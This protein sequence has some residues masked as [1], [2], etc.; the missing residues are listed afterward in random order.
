MHCP[1]TGTTSPAV[2]SCCR[3]IVEE[4]LPLYTCTDSYTGASSSGN[5]TRSY[6]ELATL[7]YVTGVKHLLIEADAVKSRM[8]MH[9][10][11]WPARRL[12]ACTA[13]HVFVESCRAAQCR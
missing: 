13:Q 6:N 12:G 8:K 2:N 10:S 9:L 1:F 11:P 3:R 4:S 7:M 5:E